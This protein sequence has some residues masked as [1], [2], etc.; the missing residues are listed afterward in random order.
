MA[1]KDPRQVWGEGGIT[2]GIC[3][4]SSH[5][6]EG[7]MHGSQAGVYAVPILTSLTRLLSWA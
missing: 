2:D 4:H 7:E 5:G 1:L 6:W 3:G